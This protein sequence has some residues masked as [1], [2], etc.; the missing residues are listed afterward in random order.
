MAFLMTQF[1]TA[2]SVDPAN[3]RLH[4]ATGQGDIGTGNNVL[5]NTGIAAAVARLAGTKHAPDADCVLA[6]VTSASPVVS[7]LLAVAVVVVPLDKATRVEGDVP[8]S[9]ASPR[10]T[11][12]RGP[13]CSSMT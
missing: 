12:Q 2:A 11:A 9:G 13:R 3:K 5:N 8:H 4:A 7:L 1:S 10:H 6:L